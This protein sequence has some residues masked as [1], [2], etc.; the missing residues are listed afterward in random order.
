MRCSP[1][2]GLGPRSSLRWH[3]P[4]SS[5]PTNFAD[6]TAHAHPGPLLY[7]QLE[8]NEDAQALA[9]GYRFLLS[10]RPTHP[11][12]LSSGFVDGLPST[13]AHAAADKIAAAIE[14]ASMALTEIAA[15]PNQRLPN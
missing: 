7:H 5:E 4:L 6:A 13:V 11:P 8:E 15:A 2:W 9:D 14:P 10:Q 3:S 1:A 12:R